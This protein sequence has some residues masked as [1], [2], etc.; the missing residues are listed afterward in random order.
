MSEADEQKEIVR[1]FRAK[2]PE[3]A[4]ALR[5]SQFGNHR[6]RSRK[7]AAIRT[8]KAVGQGAVVGESDIGICLPRKGYGSLFIEHKA[9][10]GAHK[11]TAEQQEYI[12]YHNT[13]GNCACVTKGID[14]A[15][16]AIETYMRG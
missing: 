2:W 15:K 10:D 7:D 4:R 5:V 1:W 8:A 9:E 13:E 14:A 3:H 16:A 6:G 12:K 11:T